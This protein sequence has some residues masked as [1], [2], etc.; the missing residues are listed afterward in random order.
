MIPLLKDFIDSL[1]ALPGIDVPALCAALDTA[2]GTGVRRNSHKDAGN[3]IPEILSSEESTPVSWCDGGYVLS[4]RPHFSHNPL[5]HAGAY[6]VQDSSSMIYQQITE[7]IVSLLASEK[8]S[9]GPLRVLDFCAAPGGKTTAIIN[10]LPFGSR[11]VANEYVPQRGKILRENLEK[12]GY[13]FVITT[14]AASSQYAVLPAMFDIVAVDA[15]CSGEGMMRKDDDA[16][17]QWSESLVKDCA[18]LQREILSDIAATVAPGGYLIY[19]TCTF[20]LSENEYN[21]QFIT[22]SLGFEPVAIDSLHLEGINGGTTGKPLRALTEGVEALRF[23]PHVTPTGEGQ[24]V[25][26][27]RRPNDS[28]EVSV[29]DLCNIH[30]AGKTDKK[31]KKGK[32]KEGDKKGGELSRKMADQLNGW[33]D[34]S[35]EPSFQCSG[36]LVT[37]LPSAM[38]PILNT[39]SSNKINITGAGLPIAEIK[40]SGE[41]A[42]IIPD[43]RIVLSMAYRNDAFPVA[44]LSEDDAVRYLKREAVV[45][46]SDVPKGYVAVAFEGR[47]LGLVKNLGNRANN[48]FPANWKIRI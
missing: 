14:G 44:A 41:R 19:S 23:M 38:L 25:S 40:G 21:S 34:Q 30:G 27:F 6:Y 3:P 32:K 10:A 9:S 8:D 11:V 29:N 42:D 37:M 33:I 2:P 22:D 24:Y 4:E 31:D 13:P 5:W 46:S 17:R 48:L 12:W 36:N 16:R 39:L 28:E 45:L 15:P 26:V 43:S 47:P 1:A 35:I 7:R 18:S 20:N